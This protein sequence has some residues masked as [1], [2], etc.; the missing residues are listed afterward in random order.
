MKNCEWPDTN[1]AL[2]SAPPYLGIERL[3]FAD[4]TWRAAAQVREAVEKTAG[5]LLEHRTVCRTE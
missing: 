1:V 3:V 4:R 2:V 5:G